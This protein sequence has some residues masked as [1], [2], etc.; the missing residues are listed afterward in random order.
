[1]RMVRSFVA[2]SLVLATAVVNPT[3]A[4][5]LSPTTI[6]G[7]RRRVPGHAA[8]GLSFDAERGFGVEL[9]RFRSLLHLLPS[10]QRAPSP[11]TATACPS[12][13]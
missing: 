13:T 3:P 12:Q 2:A 5:A 11:L 8:H 1:M 7:G 6:Q 4:Q 9:V 10:R